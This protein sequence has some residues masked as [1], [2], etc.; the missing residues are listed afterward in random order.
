MIQ[1]HQHILW[2]SYV[3]LDFTSTGV[4]HCTQALLRTTPCNI[5]QPFS[6]LSARRAFCIVRSFWVRHFGRWTFLFPFIFTTTTPFMV[7]GRTTNKHEIYDVH[8][9]I[10]STEDRDWTGQNNNMGTDRIWDGKKDV[11][12]QSKSEMERRERGR[13][14][15]DSIDE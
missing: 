11:G 15:G 10:Q 1:E 6:F 2:R 5:G 4:Q 12:C 9:I 8:D 13:R 14:H 3:S 7:R